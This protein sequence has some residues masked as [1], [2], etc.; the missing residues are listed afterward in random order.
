MKV[1][2]F[3]IEVWIDDN[4]YKLRSEEELAELKQIEIKDFFLS[5]GMKVKQI[6]D[7]MQNVGCLPQDLYLDGNEYE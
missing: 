4:E 7:E 2:S 6:F 3:I 5:V 1:A